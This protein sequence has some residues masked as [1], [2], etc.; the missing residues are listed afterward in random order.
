MTL[1]LPKQDRH[2]NCVPF[3]VLNQKTGT[4]LYKG[5][6]KEIA[7][8]LKISEGY[9]SNLHTAKKAYRKIYQI[10]RMGYA[11]TITLG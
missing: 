9:A 11:Q 2:G 3:V 7:K 6:L 5:S 8:K 4:M 10:Q 1:K